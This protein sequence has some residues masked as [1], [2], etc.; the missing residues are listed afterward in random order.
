MSAEHRLS[1]K[2]AQHRN[3]VLK[4]GTI[5]FKG[6]SI[7]CVVRNISAAGAALE[8]ESQIGIPPSFYLVI[9]ADQVKKR[10]RVLWRKERRLGVAFE[11]EPSA[12]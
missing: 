2:R 5:V 1:E 10:C 7:D 8:V 3:R 12:H 11:S 4:A 9:L 6:S